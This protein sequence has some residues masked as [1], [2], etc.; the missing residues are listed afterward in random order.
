MKQQLLIVS[1]MV[2]TLLLPQPTKANENH[3][4]NQRKASHRGRCR[5]RKAFPVFVV[6]QSYGNRIRTAFSSKIRDWASHSA[7][8]PSRD[9]R[10]SW[11][12]DRP[13]QSEHFGQ[14]ERESSSLHPS[15]EYVELNQ[16]QTFFVGIPGSF[17][18]FAENEKPL[19]GNSWEA[20]CRYVQNCRRSCPRLW[21][22]SD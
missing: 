19:E 22:S 6:L 16:R 3:R 4:I 10:L 7:A 21:R 15:S 14:P 20:P 18:W 12:S 2:A 8:A 9:E 13:Y 11:L 17:V 1:V 5:L